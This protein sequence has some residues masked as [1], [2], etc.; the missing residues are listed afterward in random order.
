PLIQVIRVALPPGLL[1]KS[2]RRL[3][4]TPLGKENITGYISPTAQNILS[5]KQFKKMINSL[6]L[7][8]N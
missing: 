7:K 3:R 2:Q 1:G 5:L 8:K 4:L 6:L